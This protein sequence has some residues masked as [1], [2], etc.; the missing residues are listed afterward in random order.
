MSIKSSRSN[1]FK[2]LDALTVHK[3]FFKCLIR[4]KAVHENSEGGRS[5]NRLASSVVDPDSGLQKLPTKI[6]KVCKI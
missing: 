3:T 5:G 2:E 4:R 1:S 6:E